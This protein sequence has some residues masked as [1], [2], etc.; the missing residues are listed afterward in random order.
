M[1]DRFIDSEL[2]KAH[3]YLS[4][5]IDLRKCTKIDFKYRTVKIHK[6]AYLV[7]KWQRYFLTILKCLLW[8]WFRGIKVRRAYFSACKPLGSPLLHASLRCFHK[9][10]TTSHL[11]LYTI[12]RPLKHTLGLN[13][14]S[15]NLYWH[16][17]NLYWQSYGLKWTVLA[18][19]RSPTAFSR[20]LTA[21]NNI[22][23]SFQILTAST[24]ILKTSTNILS[25]PVT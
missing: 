6:N 24:S 12:S 4:F 10:S 2:A 3:F 20:N 21:Y 19:S 14:H 1:K 8:R 22:K 5:A 11:G 17:Y 15:H 7:H 23:S 9:A 18:S 13:W 16:Y 25:L